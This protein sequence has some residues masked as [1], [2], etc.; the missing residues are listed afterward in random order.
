MKTEP[1][2]EELMEN[3]Y[4]LAYN[5]NERSWEEAAKLMLE[6]GI[7]TAQLVEWVDS[8]EPSSNED[9]T[10]RAEM[11]ETAL[12]LKTALEICNYEPRT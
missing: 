11:F 6:N 1:L 10:I 7:D 12:Y 5:M 4:Q 3:L 8:Q 9:W 2:N